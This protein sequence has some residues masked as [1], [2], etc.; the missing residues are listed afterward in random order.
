MSGTNSKSGIAFWLA[1]RIC[2]LLGITFP[3]SPFLRTIS[4]VWPITARRY[5]AV[6]EIGQ[7]ALI[8]DFTAIPK[9]LGSPK[10]VMIDYN[11]WQ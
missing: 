6:I 9:F 3:I 7:D 2:F 5:R 10:N 4:M 11:E 1:S 8:N